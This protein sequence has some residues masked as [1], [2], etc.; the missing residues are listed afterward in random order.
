MSRALLLLAG[1]ALAW[2]ARALD[3]PHGR[4]TLGEPLGQVALRCGEPTLWDQRL[5]ELVVSLPD[6]SQLDRSRT[7]DEWTYDLGPDRLIRILVFHDG[8][9][10]DLRTGGY[11]GLS[12]AQPGE[13]PAL[14][15]VGDSKSLVLL[16]WGEPAYSEQT[17]R[18]RTR[19]GPG[20]VRVSRSVRIDRWTYEFGPRRFRR[21]LTF[22]DGKLTENRSGDRGG[23]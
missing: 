18:L 6:G 13:R 19:L 15:S 23:R 5:Q 4:V 2:P 14:I 7:V 9:L 1:L 11:G 12:P 20:G 22:Q 10:V 21:I 17:T 16:R 3:C 8:Q